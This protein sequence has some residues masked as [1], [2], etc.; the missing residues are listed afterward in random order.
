MSCEL[1]L[2]PRH[3]LSYFKTA[4]WEQEWIE[5]AKELVCDTFQQSYQ[6]EDA[7]DQDKTPP[8]R[9]STGTEV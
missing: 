5:T 8:A 3:K 7:R 6:P 2:H 9:S 4:G 1:V